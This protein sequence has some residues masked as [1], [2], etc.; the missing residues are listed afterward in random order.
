VGNFEKYYGESP[1]ILSLYSYKENKDP[2]YALVLNI[3]GKDSTHM[4]K[5]IPSLKTDFTIGEGLLHEQAKVFT[6]KGID[7]FPK[8]L[9]IHTPQVGGQ[10][11]IEGLR[12]F[13]GNDYQNH[14]LCIESLDYI[15]MYILSICVRYK[16]VLWGQVISGESSGILSLIELY[17]NSIKRRFPNKILDSFF[18]ERFVYGT[19]SYF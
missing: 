7:A 6:S 18:N 2:K 14:F 9:G 5:T 8:Y 10:Y 17:I 16:Q 11:L 12:F 15:A 3:S 13:N 1:S 19:T 4:L